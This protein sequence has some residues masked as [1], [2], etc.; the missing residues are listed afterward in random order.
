LRGLF[1]PHFREYRIPLKYVSYGLRGGRDAT[2]GCG[3]ADTVRGLIDDQPYAGISTGSFP[4]IAHPR[5]SELVGRSSNSSKSGCANRTPASATRIRPPARIAEQG[6]CCGHDR[7]SR[8]FEDPAARA[9][10]GPRRRYSG[11]TGLHLGDARGSVRCLSLVHRGRLRFHIGGP[12]TVSNQRTRQTTAPLERCP[13]I[14]ARE[15]AADVACV[16]WTAL[17]E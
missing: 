7:Q 4:A 9:F 15:R 1:G 8:A 6:V 17:R 12:E 11:Q 16:K 5:G 10:G 13:P 2:N 14:L 3:S